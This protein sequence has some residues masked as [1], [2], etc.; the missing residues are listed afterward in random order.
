MAPNCYGYSSNQ[1]ANLQADNLKNHH[2]VSFLNFI[3]KLVCCMV[4][5]QLLEHF[6]VHNLENLYQSAFKT[7]HLTEAVLLSTKK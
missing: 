6:H 2:P 3:S 1:K 7:G 5:K 4:A